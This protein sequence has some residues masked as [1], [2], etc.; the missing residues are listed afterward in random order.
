MGEVD[1][2][3][4]VCLNGKRRRNEDCLACHEIP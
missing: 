1:I 4:K 2:R 3:D